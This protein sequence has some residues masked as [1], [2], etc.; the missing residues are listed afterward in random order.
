[1]DEKELKQ[2]LKAAKKDGLSSLK[3]LVKDAVTNVDDDDRLIDD[4]DTILDKGKEILR[5]KREIRKNKPKGLPIKRILSI[6][7]KDD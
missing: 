6:G 3:K 5:I 4:M 1:M 7:K 2:Q